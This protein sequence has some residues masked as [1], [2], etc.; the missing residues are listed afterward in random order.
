MLLRRFR[1]MA[2]WLAPLCV[3]GLGACY[4]Y[5]PAEVGAPTRGTTVRTRLE[6]E[7]TYEVGDRRIH[8]IAAVEGEVIAWEPDTLAL[9]A[10]EVL[11]VG[12]E[13]FAGQGYTVRLPLAQIS[14]LTIKR[15]DKAR[16]ILL[17]LGTA[18]AAVLAQQALSNGFG[19]GDGPGGGGQT[20]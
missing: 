16:T 4:T 11:G 10:A 5:V 15:L 1:A 19:S 9:S 18:L 20:K 2:R 13:S 14:G 8:D 12:G 7:P 17:A 3:I 6:G